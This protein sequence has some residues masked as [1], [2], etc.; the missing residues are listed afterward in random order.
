MRQKEILIENV[1]QGP[2]VDWLNRA[3]IRD[4]DRVN[5]ARFKF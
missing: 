5:L 2:I 1:N 4:F 3:L